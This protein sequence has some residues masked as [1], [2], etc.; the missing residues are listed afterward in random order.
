MAEVEDYCIGILG[1]GGESKGETSKKADDGNLILTGGSPVS[2]CRWP[3]GCQG[4]R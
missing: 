2:D 3:G 4:E 1:G